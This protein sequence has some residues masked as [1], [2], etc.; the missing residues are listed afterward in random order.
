M[1]SAFSERTAMSFVSKQIRQ[2]D[3]SDGIEISEVE[4]QV[5]LVLRE[6]QDGE[7]FCKYIYYYDGYLYELY[8]KE[9]F[10]PVL[11]AGQ[12]LIEIDGWDIVANENGT[13]TVTILED[14]A[15][16]SSQ[17]TLSLRSE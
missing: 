14:E 1:E 5:A 3:R 12:A 8:A 17:L 11:A 6:E 4:G 15:E 7:V 9:A 13:L 2:N 16:K 10:E